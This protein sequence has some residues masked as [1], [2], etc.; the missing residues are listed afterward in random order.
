MRAEAGPA[1]MGDTRPDSSGALARCVGDT[2]RFLDSRWAQ[3]VHLHRGGRAG[4]LL[5]VDDVERIVESTALRAP[6]FRLVKGGMTLDAASCTR[7]ARIG[8]RTVTDLIDVGR[9]YDHLATGATLVLQGLHRYWPPVGDLCRDLE[10][11]LTHPVQANAY[12]TPPVAQ[13]LN[14]HADRH[15]VFA[16]QTHGSKQWV[17]YEGDQQPGADGSSGAPTLDAQLHPGDCLYLPKGVHHAA[18]TVDSFSIHLTLGVRAVTWADVL[19]TAV[20]HAASDH[21]LQQALP[22]GF[23]R[24]PEALAEEAGRR[25]RTLVER[26]TPVDAAEALA[27]TAHGFWSSRPPP[28]RG[29]LRQ[30][31]ELADIDDATLVRPRSGIQG[32]ITEDGHTVQLALADRTL[33]LPASAEPAL[34]AALRPGGLKVADLSEHLDPAGRVTLVRCLVREGALMVVDG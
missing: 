32:E 16:L 14:V 23:A 8:S 25:L 13:G 9:V 22:A 28:L 12:I 3:G 30:L 20:E 4:G 19:A 15:D 1:P 5:D 18:R 10:D 24:E 26:L 31:I 33:R 6:A 7:R 21:S 29:Q 17:V 11:T 2:R 27:K 34:R